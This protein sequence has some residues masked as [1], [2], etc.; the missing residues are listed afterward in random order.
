MAH[1]A[2]NASC[3]PKR[4]QMSGH[5]DNFISEYSLQFAKELLCTLVV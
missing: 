3:G 5:R 4:T 2:Q 1:A